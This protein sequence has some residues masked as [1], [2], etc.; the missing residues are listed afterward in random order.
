[1]LTGS[2]ISNADLRMT[3][4]CW[5]PDAGD[6]IIRT[7][8]IKNAASEA[9]F[10]FIYPLLLVYQF[11]QGKVDTVRREISDLKTMR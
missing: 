5:G 11:G 1:M 8:A 9:A 4:S 6:L 7:G 3:T 2:T 10:V